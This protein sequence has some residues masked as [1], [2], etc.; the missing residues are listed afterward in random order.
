MAKC[1]VE[2]GVTLKIDD[3]YIKTNVGFHEDYEQDPE[4][5]NAKEINDILIAR[6]NENMIDNIVKQLK[7][8]RK[9]E[10]I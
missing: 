10:F 6:C 7:A 1:I 4:G 3:A 9:K 5:N 8:L 2:V